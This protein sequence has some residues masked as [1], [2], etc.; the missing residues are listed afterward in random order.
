MSE[1]LIN[2]MVLKA[3]SYMSEFQGCLEAKAAES[4]RSK[5]SKVGQV[6]FL[7]GEAKESEAIDEKSSN[8]S[9][10]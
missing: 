6:N 3:T 1:N 9:T 5:S 2:L 10:S 4:L 7:V 8:R